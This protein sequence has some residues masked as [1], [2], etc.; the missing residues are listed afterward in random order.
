MNYFKG[1]LFK[2]KKTLV[3]PLVNEN[4]ETAYSNGQKS[5]FFAK[6]FE[7]SHLLTKDWSS[8]HEVKVKK[9]LKKLKSDK[10]TILDQ[11]YTNSREICEI[12]KNLKRNKAPGMDRIT[13]LMIKNL[14]KKAFDFIAKIFNSCFKISYFPLEWKHASIFAIQKPG[15]K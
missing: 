6:A 5:D 12:V 8:K 3:P 15:K 7:S 14:P 1:I 4:N 10:T 11:V 2:R 13:N 9:S